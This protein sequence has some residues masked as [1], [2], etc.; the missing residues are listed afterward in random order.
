[1]KKIIITLLFLVS[2]CIFA[3]D[4]I[5]HLPG[6]SKP[7]TQEYA[8]YVPAGKQA[9][10]FYWFVAS[11]KSN[12]PLIV[13]TNGGPGY[14]S[15]YGFFN[16]TGPYAVTPT[17]Q[18]KSRK[19]GWNH[20]A[21]YLIIDQPA[22]VGLSHIKH[23]QL[24]ANRAQATDQYYEALVSF[25]RAYPAYRHSPVFL[26]GESYAGTALPLVAQK[27][28]ADEKE[29]HIHLKGLILMSPWADPHLQQSM[30]SLYAYTHGLI[31]QSQKD[32]IDAIYR[33]CDALIESGQDTEANKTCN[34]ID[35][36]IQ[37]ISGLNLANIAYVSSADNTL[38]D[39]YLNQ[40]AVL[41][42]IHARPDKKFECFSGLANSI[43]IDAIQ[44]SVK[45]IY[46]Q[47]LSQH[48]PIIIFS[49]LND[50]KDTNFLGVK[51]LMYSF[52]W[53]GADTFY[54]SETT[55]VMDNKTVLGYKQ[56][57]GG[58]TWVTVLNAGHMIPLDQPR[59]A[60]VV[61]KFVGR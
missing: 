15:I 14:S 21:N 55:P 38:L 45:S 59:V 43:Y 8:G 60:I 23:N 34:L 25:F 27:I 2:H 28:L 30:D 9:A 26:A 22:E 53:P 6:L 37:Q 36:R 5:T 40:P 31:S 20:F 48:I 56:S 24:P 46:N 10:L 52:Q 18:L 50:A 57:G 35:G 47:L 19:E 13:W 12:A 42:A 49:G 61:K 33:H 29:N 41:K 58:L 44:K 39:R 16:E 3:N 32:Q 51:K 4:A 17:L 11:H 7:V 54:K 1:M